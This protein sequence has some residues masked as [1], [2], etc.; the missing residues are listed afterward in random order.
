MIYAAWTGLAEAE[1]TLP[2]LEGLMPLAEKHPILQ[3][4]LQ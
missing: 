4:L 1:R 3:V 2:A